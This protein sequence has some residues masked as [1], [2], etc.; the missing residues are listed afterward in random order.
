MKKLL[1]EWRYYIHENYGNYG[2]VSTVQKLIFSSVP[3]MVQDEWI[4]PIDTDGGEIEKAKYW[5]S[6][7][8]LT[9]ESIDA[10]KLSEEL[11][12]RILYPLRAWNAI[13]K[14]AN[15]KWGDI[16]LSHIVEELGDISIE[17]LTEQLIDTMV[18]EIT[19][20]NNDPAIIEFFN[21]QKEALRS[22]KGDIIQRAEK[23]GSAPSHRNALHDFYGL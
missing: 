1:N 4:D 6:S 15:G 7:K 8:E 21:S 12:E 19:E 10:S 17:E 23:I 16:W 18:D 14:N 13:K 5:N 9:P 2:N 22:K 20:V 3:E 11:I